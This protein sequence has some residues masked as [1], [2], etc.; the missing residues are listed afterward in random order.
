MI[1][2]NDETV[3]FY[4][5]AS[6]LNGTNFVPGTA[7][8]AAG[9][10]TATFR[11]ASNGFVDMTAGVLNGTPGDNYVATFVVTSPPVVVGIP[12]F[13]AGPGNA[14]NLFG[15][16]IGIP[17]SLS[18]GSSAT[19]GTFTLQF[20]PSL[21]DIT[22]VTGN[23]QTIALTGSPTGGTFTLAFNGA[24]TTSI[25]YSSVATTLQANIQSAL[26]S[27]PNIGPGNSYV[28]VGSSATTYHVALIGALAAANQP[29]FTASGSGLVPSGSLTVTNNTLTGETFKL[30]SSSN[31]AA[32]TAVLDMSASTAL[33]GSN[34]C[35]GM[36]IANVPATA[37]SN[38]L[39]QTLLHFSPSRSPIAAAL[40]QSRMATELKSSTISVTLP[41]TAA[42][43]A[44]MRH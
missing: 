5:T 39:T 27:L 3:T 10:Y 15:N 18:T 1:S 7:E 23:I 37:S 19:A 2:P 30:D 43:P 40:S 26:N 41:A 6:V 4:K 44:P 21:L 38:Y 42:I 20:N 35:M 17:V 9:T 24:T 29:A 34:V 11:S 33:S 32:G 16:S 22:S 14:V 12:D 13:A 31:L 36:L 25:A 28:N 8:W